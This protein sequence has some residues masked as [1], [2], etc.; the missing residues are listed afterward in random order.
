MDQVGENLGVAWWTVQDAVNAAAVVL[1]PVDDLRVHHLGID[2]GY[3]PFAGAHRY[4]RVWFFRD[5]ES[6]SW[7]RV[8]PWMTT[9]VNVACG[10]VLGVMA[11]DP[12]TTFRKAITTAL[13][14]ARISVDPFH[15]VQLANLMVTR[16]RQRLAQANHG[17]RAR[18]DPPAPAA[19]RRRHSHRAG[20]GTP[21][22][23]LQDR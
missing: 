10:Q 13:P 11:I 19:A 22:D 12:S 8:E 4:R 1:P 2:W 6:G 17:R 5:P 9:F 3:L 23:H 14:H 20:P 15:L 18:L 16:V 7:T 21:A